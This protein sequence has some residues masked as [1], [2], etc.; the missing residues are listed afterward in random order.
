MIRRYGLTMVRHIAVLI[1][2]F[3]L[4]ALPFGMGSMMAVQ[5]G[6]DHHAAHRANHDRAAPANHALHSD[7]HPGTPS[8]A[9]EVLGLL[10]LGHGNA[11]GGGTMD[12]DL[13]DAGAHLHFAACGSC[14]SL[15]AVMGDDLPLPSDGQPQDM[16]AF[17]S[18]DS[19][20]TLPAL[21]PPRA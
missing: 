15:P 7:N 4:A 17:A 9:Q 2:A 5:A 1:L 12:A 18:L 11:P 14:L 21:P 19:L 16:L 13:P 20:E 10:Q 8:Q 3:A 6:A